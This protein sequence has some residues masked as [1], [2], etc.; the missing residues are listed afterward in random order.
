[1]PRLTKDE[2]NQLVG[3]LNG[4]AS[5]AT[6]ARRFNVTRRTVYVTRDRE[7]TTGSQNDRPR[8]LGRRKT[9]VRED[10][11]IRQSHLRNRFKTEGQTRD[12]LNNIRIYSQI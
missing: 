1:M 2:R 11:F 10:N 3:M 5:V 8:R 7:I 4:G 12:E 9:T 6:V